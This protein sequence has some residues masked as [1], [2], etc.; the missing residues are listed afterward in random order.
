[1]TKQ[2]DDTSTDYQAR[3]EELEQLLRD[4]LLYIKEH[5]SEYNWRNAPPII[6]LQDR[7]AALGIVLELKPWASLKHLFKYPQRV[8]YALKSRGVIITAMLLT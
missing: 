3:A 4:A 1:M 6:R 7:A 5:F 2:T 8:R